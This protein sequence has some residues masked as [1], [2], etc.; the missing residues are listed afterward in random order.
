MIKYYR[1]YHTLTS[2]W[3]GLGCFCYSFTQLHNHTE[4]DDDAHTTF[5]YK[6]HSCNHRPHHHDD[7]KS[8]D[9][10]SRTLQ[11]SLCYSN[12]RSARHLPPPGSQGRDYHHTRPLPPVFPSGS[13]RRI[14]V[15]SSIDKT[16]T[17]TMFDVFNDDIRLEA[18]IRTKDEARKLIFHELKLLCQMLI[19]PSHQTSIS[20]A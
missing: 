13:A 16:I 6:S 2:R 12:A 5:S 7:E 18:A 20:Q 10:S 9:Q 1:V 19:E 3:I 17:T 4:T 15:S 14:V 11:Q 8:R